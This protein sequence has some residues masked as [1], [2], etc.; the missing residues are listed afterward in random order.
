VSRRASTPWTSTSIKSTNW[1]KNELQ[2]A[3]N[4]L[5]DLGDLPAGI[6][7]GR[8]RSA[9]TRR[10]RRRPGRRRHASRRRRD[11]PWSVDESP[12]DAV[13]PPV[14]RTFAIH[15]PPVDANK[16]P[17]DAFDTSFDAIA[18]IDVSAR[19]FRTVDAPFH[20]VSPFQ[21]PARILRALDTTIVPR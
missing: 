5:D 6:A 11:E 21:F 14:D 18:T 2:E 4:F 3:F 12:F 9:G 8:L 17:V 7:A 10:R 20:S 13:E 15:E 1:V 16:P 19:L